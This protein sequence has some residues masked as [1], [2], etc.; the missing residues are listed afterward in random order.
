MVSLAGFG[1]VTSQRM[2]SILPIDGSGRLELSATRCEGLASFE[3][4]GDDWRV[5]G[6]YGCDS[7]VCSTEKPQPAAKGD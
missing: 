2:G 1:R 4:P 6:G 5:P 3:L 7:S